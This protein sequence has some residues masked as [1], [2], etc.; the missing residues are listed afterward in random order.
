[1][2]VMIEHPGKLKTKP[3]PGAPRVG[4]RVSPG[5]VPR[6]TGPGKLPKASADRH[7]RLRA[8]I[9]E[10]AAKHAAGGY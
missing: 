2:S 1:M 3:V 6:N 10:R 4:T 5:V 7:T 8:R 9:A